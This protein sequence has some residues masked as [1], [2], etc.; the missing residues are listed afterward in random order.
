MEQKQLDK[1]WDEVQE[2][3]Y[4][5]QDKLVEYRKLEDKHSDAWYFGY[6][7]GSLEWDGGDLVDE[8]I[9]G[10]RGGQVQKSFRKML[11]AKDGKS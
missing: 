6:I 4:K 8:V 7:L 3:F 2:I 1:K 11:E 9:W 10:I 5:F